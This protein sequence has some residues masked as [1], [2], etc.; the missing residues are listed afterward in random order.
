MGISSSDGNTVECCGIEQCGNISEEKVYEDPAPDVCCKN[1][2]AYRFDYKGFVHDAK[3]SP[4][5][6]NS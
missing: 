2:V 3:D 6:K 1:N 4:C 5:K